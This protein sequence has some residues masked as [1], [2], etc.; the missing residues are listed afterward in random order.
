MNHYRPYAPTE[1][2]P[3]RGCFFYG[4]LTAS[5][6]LV[7]IGIGLGY[8]AYLMKGYYDQ[9][10]NSLALTPAVTVQAQ[11]TPDQEQRLGDRLTRM[12]SELERGQSVALLLSSAE[13][14]TLIQSAVSH[15]A[16]IQRLPVNVQ[17]HAGIATVE[18]SVPIGDKFLNGKADLEIELG[19]NKRFQLRNVEIN[20]SQVKGALAD[21]IYS[22]RMEDA[23]NFSSESNELSDFVKSIESLKIEGDQVRIVFKPNSPALTL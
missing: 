9:F 4:C 11:L 10:N 5:V 8:L 16:D 2:K 22:T 15:N 12:K 3:E 19:R 1:P 14:N 18:F 13:I 23:I 17:L 7:L 20:G 21:M 6:F